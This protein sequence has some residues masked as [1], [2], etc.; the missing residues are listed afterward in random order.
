MAKEKENVINDLARE[1]TR[2]LAMLSRTTLPIDEH[3]FITDLISSVNDMERVGDHAMN[4]L[5]LAEFRAEYRLPF[6]K[7]A[8]NELIDMASKAQE[9][10]DLA[11]YSFLHW[12]ES[13][14]RKVV[15]SEEETDI[16]EKVYVLIILS[17]LM[18]GHNPSSEQFSIF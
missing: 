18:R 7:E 17:D 5:E 6:S 9:T 1:T 16:K 10:F 14:S 15:K 4:I 8:I 13:S 12:D 11:I 3:N 2:F